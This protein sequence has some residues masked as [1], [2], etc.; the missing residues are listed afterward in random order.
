MLFFSLFNPFSFGSETLTRLRVLWKAPSRG[1]LPHIHGVFTTQPL[2]QML[3]FPHLTFLRALPV[4]SQAGHGQLR[5]LLNTYSHPCSCQSAHPAVNPSS[6]TQQRLTRGLTT[7]FISLSLS[8]LV[9]IH[10]SPALIHL[11]KSDVY[12]NINRHSFSFQQHKDL[13]CVFQVYSLT[14]LMFHLQ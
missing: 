6:Q 9:S 7:R 10:H 2:C 14:G 8:S 11:R 12:E 5:F 4:R 13:S 1:L 3:L